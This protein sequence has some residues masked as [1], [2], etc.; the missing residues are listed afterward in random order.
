MPRLP[1]SGREVRIRPQNG[2][3][4]LLLL[5]SDGN[6]VAAAVA[7]L[8]RVAEPA[9]GGD[10]EWGAL[11]VTDF[12][13]L[14]ATLRVAVL[15]QHVACAFDCPRAS[16]GQR[17]EVR[18]RLADYVAPV[19]LRAAAGVS[20]CAG[21]PG[22]FRLGDAQAA[23]RL[24]TAAD[25]QAV[26]GEAGAAR[27]LAARC[28]DPPDMAAPLRARAERA[29]AAMAPEVSRPVSGTCPGC[30]ALVRAGLH[31]PGLVIAELRR[32]AAGL[33]EEVHLL[34]S[35]YHWQEAAILALPRARRLAY[36]ERARERLAGAA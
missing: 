11:T 25:Q 14:V 18:F 21:R 13:L 19:R 12:E 27:L 10:S 2:A 9:D 20:E 1:V 32:A 24:P 30:G 6:A 23:F 36:A 28:L 8:A 31:L 33:H 29:M 4:D 17:G 26:L 35:A 3:D 15:G 7:L 22:W 16:C 34:A 5:E